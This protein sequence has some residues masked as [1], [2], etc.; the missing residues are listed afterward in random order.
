MVESPALK[1]DPVANAPATDDFQGQT[2]RF[3]LL[4]STPSSH[5]LSVSYIIGLAFSKRR[6]EP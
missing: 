2:P 4:F 1:F 3:V 6:L 5:F